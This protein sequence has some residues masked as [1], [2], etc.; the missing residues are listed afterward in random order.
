MPVRNCSGERDLDRYVELRVV[1]LDGGRS[2]LGAELLDHV[3]YSGAVS[4]RRGPCAQHGFPGR[5]DDGPVLQQVPVPLAVRA[6]HGQHVEL[7]P[8]ADEPDRV[9]DRPARPP[10]RDGDLDLVGSLTCPDELAGRS[11]R[12]SWRL[13]SSALP[14]Y[15]AHWSITWLLPASDRRTTARPPDSRPRPGRAPPQSHSAAAPAPRV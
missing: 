11:R 15:C 7:P 14:G 4:D 5:H 13:P 3:V 12:V 8:F 9:S 10:A 6:A 2:V 1:L